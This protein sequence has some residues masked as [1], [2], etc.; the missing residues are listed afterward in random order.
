MPERVNPE[1]TF[2][3]FSM[4]ESPE[5]VDYD[6]KA[7][8]ITAKATSQESIGKTYD[9]DFKFAT[10]EDYLGSYF[11]TNTGLKNYNEDFATK[12]TFN[13]VKA[14]D[15]KLSLESISED[16]LVILKFSNKVN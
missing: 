13:P 16:N 10:K 2:Y 7:N 14:V 1:N 9:L 4:T 11:A 12:I 6:K 8:K 3:T 15:L 5:F